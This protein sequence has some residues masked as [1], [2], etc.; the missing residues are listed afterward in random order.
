LFGE[1]GYAN[2]KQQPARGSLGSVEY[3]SQQQRQAGAPTPS[4]PPSTWLSNKQ[5]QYKQDQT[6][7]AVLASSDVRRPAPT[8]KPTVTGAGAAT[9][10][11]SSSTKAAAAA[12]PD[13]DPLH[14]NL[15]A[16]EKEAEQ[17][18]ALSRV[19]SQQQDTITKQVRPNHMM[20]G[21]MRSN[22]E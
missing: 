2:N 14:D 20:N 5:S 8:P 11:G 18:S 15:S 4:L 7:D 10:G 22:D 13:Y 19:I 17:L 16:S 1:D 12:D 9:T 21:C 3:D 6:D